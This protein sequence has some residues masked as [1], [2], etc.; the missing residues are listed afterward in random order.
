MA[1]FNPGDISFGETIDWLLPLDAGE[2]AVVAGDVLTLKHNIAV[3]VTGAVF[4]TAPVLRSTTNL[5]HIA[6]PICVV[7]SGGAAGDNILVRVRGRCRA[8]CAFGGG[9]AASPVP[10]YSWLLVA[11]VEAGSSFRRF[12]LSSTDVAAFACWGVTRNRLV[13]A[14][15]LVDIDLHGLSPLFR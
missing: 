10:A 2:A 4:S 8:K 14:N 13:T 5:S 1:A 9:G 6:G 3:G 15:Q 7:L 11:S 12:V